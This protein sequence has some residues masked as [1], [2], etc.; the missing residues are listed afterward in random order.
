MPTKTVKETEQ[1]NS[2][3]LIIDDEPEICQLVKGCLQQSGYFPRYAENTADAFSMLEQD[4]Y[5]AIIT[6]IMM[7]DEDGIAFL[8]RVHRTWPDIPVILMTGHAQLQM[9]VDA[10]K[11]GA[12]DFVYKPFDFDHM[13]RIVER[14]VHYTRLLRMENNYRVELEET[15]TQRTAELELAMVELDFAKSALLKSANEK[16]E[17]MS[18]ISHEMRTPMNGVVGGL[19]LLEDEVSTAEGREY[20]EIVR[21]SADNMVVLIDQLLMFGGGIGQG[22]DSA[23]Y[24]LT[25]LAANINA[26]VTEYRSSFVKKGISLKLLIASDVP[27]EIWTDK[28]RLNRLIGVLLGN[29]LKFTDQGM[30]TLE[31]S[32]EEHGGKGGRLYFA[33]TDSGIG[34]PVGMLEQIFEP[35]VQGDGSY[36]RRHG[37]V[38][39]GLAIARQNS[40]IL[41]GR[42]WAEH[43]PAGG[44]R[45]IF[46]TKALTP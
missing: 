46:S 38:G 24:D 27:D 31:V 2:Y 23:C 32:H 15:V 36:T 16:N 44:S 11:N 6:D 43:V 8:G 45:F 21:Q 7:P 12:F 30:V 41:N 35:F 4:E 5:D 37:G 40:L 9:A 29:A 1:A 10:I 28:K 42:L 14:A 19:S 3:V 22:S 18:N 34:I 25:S 13:R 39:L 33:V 20:L 17:F 26:V